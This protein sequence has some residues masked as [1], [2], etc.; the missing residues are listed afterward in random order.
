MKTS[1]FKP[2][3]RVEC[4]ANFRSWKNDD[5]LVVSESD[6]VFVNVKSDTMGTGAFYPDEIR[7][8]ENSYLGFTIGQRVKVIEKNFPEWAKADDLVVVPTE[9]DASPY[10][11]V[12]S[13]TMGGKG[14]FLPKELKAL[15]SFSQADLDREVE[16]A[17]A[18]GYN[19][20]VRVALAKVDDAIQFAKK[21][22]DL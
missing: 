7:I 9:H 6:G 16:R 22:L 11:Y 19:E 17:H 18:A 20:G 4:V 12:H 1:D 5:T 10:V 3:D 13:D 2:G 8:K 21:N 14:V 15:V